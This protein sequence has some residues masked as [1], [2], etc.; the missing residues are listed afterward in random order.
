M[1]E[2]PILKKKKITSYNFYF[3]VKLIT[4]SKSKL[5]YIKIK[6]LLLINEINN[7]FQATG[8]YENISFK[9]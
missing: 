2:D 6:I 5:N 8:C 4:F 1:F 9:I 7:R 3:S